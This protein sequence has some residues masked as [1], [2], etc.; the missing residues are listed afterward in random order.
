M[1]GIGEGYL[2]HVMKILWM[3]PQVVAGCEA[4]YNYVFELE[5]GD[6]ATCL[7]G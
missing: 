5:Y 7:R 4:F 6:F 3:L 2:N 1:Y